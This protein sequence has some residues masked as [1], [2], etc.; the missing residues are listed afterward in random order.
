MKKVFKAAVFFVSGNLYASESGFPAF[1]YFFTPKFVSMFLIAF[2]ALYLLLLG[3][4]KNGLRISILAL[5]FVLFGIVGNIPFSFFESF[6][7]H[8]S[9]I[10]AATKPFLYGLALPFW[11]TLA[12]IGILTVI[13]PKLFCSYVCPVGAVQEIVS[14]AGDKLKIVKKGFSFRLAN[15]IRFLIFV[16]FLVLSVGM[17]VTSEYNGEVFPK[18]IYDYFNPFHGLEFGA[19]KTFTALLIHYSPFVLTVLLSFKFYRPFCYFVCPVGLFTWVAEQFSLV[20]LKFDGQSCTSC[21]LCV[22]GLGCPAIGE[23]LKK[24]V[25]RPD[26]FGCYRCIDKCKFESLRFGV[27]RGN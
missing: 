25:V 5:S 4:M 7:M 6:G 16:L 19:D 22:K 18:S 10:C 11:V 14:F 20:S 12:V 24:S 3:K 27:R 8:P 9:P 21:G 13:G 17:I 2:F 1:D 15:G 26:C 23:V